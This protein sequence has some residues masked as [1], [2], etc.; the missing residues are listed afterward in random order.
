[1]IIKFTA[2]NG[3]QEHF[4]FDTDSLGKGEELEKFLL[5]TDD[6]KIYIV[7]MVMKDKIIHYPLPVLERIHS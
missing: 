3:G 7:P 4:K 6:G 5:D 2:F 1:M